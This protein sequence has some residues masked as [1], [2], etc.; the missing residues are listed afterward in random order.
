MTVKENHFKKHSNKD[1]KYSIDKRTIIEI[2]AMRCACTIEDDY[3]T[4]IHNYGF[5][6]IM[7]IRKEWIYERDEII[8]EHTMY[9]K[10]ITYLRDNQVNEN[11][12]QKK[13][14]HKV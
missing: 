13:V 1:H 8:D 4:C 9:Q 3:D 6:S 5:Q 2:L 10:L 12:A 7:D 11:M 14:H